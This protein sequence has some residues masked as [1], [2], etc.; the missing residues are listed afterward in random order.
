MGETNKIFH[1]AIPCQDLDSTIDFYEKL[2]CSVIK[3]D[4][5]K[6][7]FNFYGDLLVCHVDPDRIDFEP[8]MYSRHY[9]MTFSDKEEFD[10]ILAS[11]NKHDLLFF[12]ETMVHLQGKQG[13]HINFFLIDPSNNILE[14]NYYYDVNLAYHS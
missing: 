13:E 10:H 3:R 11:A 9:G 4:F 12:K 14:F 5:Q 2:G 7:T 1:L 8:K 6:V